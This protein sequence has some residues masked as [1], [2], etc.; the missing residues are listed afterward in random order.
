MAFKTSALSLLIIAIFLLSPGCSSV[1]GTKRKFGE[2]LMYGIVFN[3]ENMP[4]TNAEVKVD[5]RTVMLT[6]IQGRFILASR[7]RKE[8]TLTVTKEG[9][10][11]VTDVF[12]FEPMNVIHLLMINADQLVNQA[13][14][15][16]SDGRFK[17]VVTL[18]DRALALNP[19]RYDA[20]YL[21]AL[22]FV[23]LREYEQAG[24]ILEE[25]QERIGEREYIR[26]V[27]EGLPQ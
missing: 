21:K 1:K 3:E 9:Y 5:G 19:E 8:F 7:Q 16:M 2:M 24:T 18:C 6:D 4:V 17:D 20:S 27:L 26:K 13:E 10:E 11:E 12:C 25:L 22:A 14:F 15:A 23:R